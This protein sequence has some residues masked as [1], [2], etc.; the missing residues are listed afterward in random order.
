[1]KKDFLKFP[2]RKALFSTVILFSLSAIFSS[3][4]D[5]VEG[6]ISVNNAAPEKVT[7]VK[8]EAGPG[9]VYLTWTNPTNES[10]MYTKIEYTTSKGEKKYQLISKENA[11]NGV[12]KATVSGEGFQ[13]G[14]HI[15]TSKGFLSNLCPGGRICAFPKM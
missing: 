9:E 12:A 7:N 4:G 6:R 14:L 13:K 10:F 8:T 5:D 1:M 2:L 3:C 15:H 11:D